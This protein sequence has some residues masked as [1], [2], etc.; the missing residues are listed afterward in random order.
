METNQKGI[1]FMVNNTIRTDKKQCIKCKKSLPMTKDYFRVRKRN[2]DGFVGTCKVCMG[3]RYTSVKKGYKTCS[4]CLI[5]KPATAE[6][7][8]KHKSGFQ[9]WCRDCKKADYENNREEI[10][11]RRKKEYRKK[12]PKEVL[13]KGKKRCATCQEVKRVESFGKL[14]KAKIGRASCREREK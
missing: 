7:F 10:S 12:N 13:P 3:F 11:A 5:D 6:H 14:A 4:N 8:D 1:D 2:K 9:S